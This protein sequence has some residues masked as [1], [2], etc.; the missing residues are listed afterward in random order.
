MKDQSSVLIENK[1]RIHVESNRIRLTEFFIDYDR[2]R[3]GYVTRAQFSRVLDQVLKTSLTDQETN[4]LFDKYDLKNNGNVNYREFI[5]SIVRAFPDKDMNN[6]PKNFIYKNP[7]YLGTFRSMKKLN[8]SEE[9]DLRN[10]LSTLNGYCARRNLDILEKFRDYDRNNIGVVTESQFVRIMD[11][12]PLKESE[13]EILIRKYQ[14]PDRKGFINYLNF[15]NDIKSNPD[16]F[17]NSIGFPTG[18]VL[19]KEESGLS[20]QEAIDKISLASYKYG[21]RVHDF[22]KDSD[23]LRSGMVTDRQF[24]TGLTNG[25]LK[26]ANLCNEDINQLAEYFKQPN[27]RIDYKS[28]CD[29]VENVFTIPDM[30]K[31]PLA[32]VDRPPRGLL[33]KTLNGN[34]SLYEED[35]VATC[36][37]NMTERVRKYKMQVFPYF[38]DF[39]RSTAF[40]R[41]V[42]KI[43]FGRV[44]SSL[45]LMPST[46]MF[47]L[48]CKKFEDS[49]SGDI[50]YP[51]F[52]QIVDDEYVASIISDKEP[53]LDELENQDKVKANEFPPNIADIDMNEL[54]A[55]IR[56]H[57]L[58]KRI[59]VKEFFQDMDPLNSNTVTKDQFIR[60]IASFGLSSLGSFPINKAQ[61]E[62]L[63]REYIQPNDPLK[64]NWKKFESD[65]ESVFTL[66]ELEK[67]PN[68]RVAPTDIF[69]LPP[70]GTVAWDDEQLESAENYKTVIEKLKKVVNARRLDCWPPFKDYDNLSHGHVTRKQFYQSLTKIGLHMSEKDVAILEAKFM[71]KKGFN[72]LEF[73][74]KLQPT[75]VEGPKYQ[76]LK[77]E[78]DRLNAPKPIYESKPVD[79][80]QSVLRKLK[81]QVF[82]RRISIY[83]WLR[84][85]DKLNSG[86]LLKE[87]F[88]RAIDLCQLEL[89]PSEIELIINYFGSTKDERMVEYKAFCFEIEKAFTNDELEKNPLIEPMQHKPEEPVMQ[90][91]LTPDQIDSV[92]K[93]L[94]E[95]AERVRQQRIQ[96]FPR[97]EDFDRIKN[98][99]VTQN[100]FTRVLN[101]L[102]LRTVIGS[103]ELE[104]LIKKYSVRIGTRDDINYV[105]FADDVYQLGSFEFRNP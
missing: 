45:N 17:K 26:P 75:I 4:V 96:L 11:E 65:L 72:Y 1:I 50:N 103:T 79:D 14:H 101:D 36:L 70:P 6:D 15:Y 67:N 58:S 13:M 100:Q 87:T 60:C 49:V 34:L 62:A 55:R 29:S 39:D 46:E 18:P 85:H 83:E 105:A 33:S 59:R 19:S 84:D 95:I 48:L 56:S 76:D 98:G 99:Y 68:A 27:G 9:V 31:K 35:Q 78:L 89:E 53:V 64:C 44:L 32:H 88:R 73:L 52:C 77:D 40:T 24:V 47:T 23:G 38:K 90:N 21:I 94:R 10:L 12:P 37:K 28:F 41:S 16:V 61:T 51:L 93:S 91:N 5:N 74:T 102:K 20:V 71:N 97:F 7:E 57:V 66:H 82:R 104:Y 3:S 81:D 2:L 80:V 22:F 92:N 42:S 69:I 30:E 54:L 8:E 63:C 86:R 43:Q 25:F